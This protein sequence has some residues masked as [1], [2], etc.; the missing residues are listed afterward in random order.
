MHELEERR[1]VPFIQRPEGSFVAVAEHPGHQLGIG[2]RILL[3]L[4][5]WLGSHV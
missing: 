4:H 5:L 1:G 3:L 2:L